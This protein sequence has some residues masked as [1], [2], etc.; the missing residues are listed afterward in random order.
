MQLA[1]VCLLL[2]CLNY[3]C[4]QTLQEQCCLLLLMSRSDHLLLLPAV[5][6]VLELLGSCCQWMLPA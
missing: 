1:G 6:L 4:L 3:L 2:T 5:V